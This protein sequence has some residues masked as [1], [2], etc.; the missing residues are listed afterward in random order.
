MNKRKLEELSLKRIFKGLIRRIFN[1]PHKISW[2]FS[3]QALNNRKKLEKYKNIHKGQRCFLIANGPSL[4]K[5]NINLLRNE[6]TFGLNRIYLNYPNMLFKPNYLVCI[7][8]LVLNQFANEF[9]N[10]SMP[11]FINWQC[12]NRFKDQNNIYYL[13]QNFSPSHFS[14]NISKSIT[15]SATVTFAALQIIYY[16][17]FKEVII[18]GMDHNFVYKGKPNEAQKRTEDKDVNHF[19]PDYFPKGMKWETPDLR[20]TEYFYQEAKQK[21]EI[22]NRRIFDATIDG[23]CQIFEKRELE[24][25]FI[26]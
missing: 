21:F 13:E 10:E 5:T 4:I 12:R 7:N 19:S 1:I 16:M 22:D 25:F 9:K 20:A 18:I 15:P 2:N 8:K 11:K 3:R 6:I 17:G 23:K 14:E 24:S 26:K